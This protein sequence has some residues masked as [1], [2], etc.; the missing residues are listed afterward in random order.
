MKEDELL[1]LSRAYADKTIEGYIPRVDEVMKQVISQFIE[2]AYQAG[3]DQHKSGVWEYC[4][5]CGTRCW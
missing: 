2:R 1:A 4:P 3:F 5:T